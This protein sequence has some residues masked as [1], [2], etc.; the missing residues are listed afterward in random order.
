M[1]DSK[2]LELG[3]IRLGIGGKRDGSQQGEKENR[4]YSG[5]TRHCLLNKLTALQR[6]FRTRNCMCFQTVE[7]DWP[8]ANAVN[9]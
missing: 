1:R 3:G 9:P 8:T 5:A 2:K 7:R 4:F 6:P